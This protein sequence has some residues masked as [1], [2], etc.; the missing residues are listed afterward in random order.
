MRFAQGGN[1]IRSKAAN[2]SAILQM[3]YHHGPIKRPV[4]ADT[5]G[6]TRPTITTTVKSMIEK[7]IV[8]EI[9]SPQHL[10]SNEGTPLG[11]R[12]Y[13]VDIVP[14]S[15]Y[16]IGAEMRGIHRAVCITDFRGHVV[17]SNEDN[18][19]CH[20]YARSIELTGQLIQDAFQNGG[21]PKE[22][23]AG[24]GLCVPGLVDND[25]GYLEIHPGYNW[26]NKNLR[27]DISQY[28][29]YDGPITVSN[30]AYA[31]AQSAQLF[32]HDRPI[33]D[34]FAYLFIATGIACP[35]ILNDSS[36]YGSVVGLGEIGHV[37][38]NPNGPLCACGNRG[39]LEAYASDRAILTSCQ[40]L[41]Q[42]GRA[43]TLAA[44]CTT[45]NITMEHVLQAQAAEDEAVCEIVNRAICQLGIV[46]ANACNFA[47][48]QTL[49][50][51]GALFNEQANR[52]T[53]LKIVEKNRYGATR[54]HTDIV[55]FLPNSL[56]GAIGAAAVSIAHNLENYQE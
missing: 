48:P 35:M 31:R 23:I 15:N 53:F 13:P 34:T 11:R 4:I 16:F 39:C 30:N 17:Y 27:H 1:P 55:F 22:K 45:K 24:I 5:L 49:F 7:G 36:A 2:Q 32:W 37:V 41:L 43:P 46:I 56:S 29:D 44:L 52:K 10:P 50:I 8:T 51:E 20:D 47:C 26:K 19:K 21:I 18:T 6:L 40:N 42:H 28:I 12:A 38:R 25:S 3:I 9:T 33:G 14:E 54:S